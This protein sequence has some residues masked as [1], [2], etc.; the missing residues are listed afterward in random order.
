MKKRILFIVGMH[1]SGTSLAANWLHACGL[2]L[3]NE[4]IGA[5]FSNVKGH[6]E[7][8][9][10]V[11]FHVKLLRF[12]NNNLYAKLNEP[13]TTN[14]YHE[15]KAKSLVY[16][17]NLLSSQWG[18][19]QPR[20]TLFLPLWR[21]VLPLARY[22]IPFRHYKQVVFSLWNRE[23]KKLAIKNQ[24]NDELIKTLQHDFLAKKEEIC[25]NYLSMW[26]RHNQEVLEHLSHLE[27]DRKLLVEVKDFVANDKAIFD[28]LTE[29]WEFELNY[30]PLASIYEPKLMHQEEIGTLN[31]NLHRLAEETYQA[32]KEQ[33]K[34]SGI[35]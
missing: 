28:R 4:L 20:I 16:L 31:T 35:F 10:F 13:M 12:N 14:E 7:D 23:Y 17:R 33:A 24:G 2:D 15:A 5:T 27:T 26:I 21:K 9:D 11:E 25:N 22:L 8:L 6:F 32:L 29:K 19:K 30:V 3:G 18:V 1:R 34:I